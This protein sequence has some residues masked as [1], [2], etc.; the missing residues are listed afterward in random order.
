MGSTPLQK[1]V[2][3]GNICHERLACSSAQDWQNNRTEL[4]LLFSFK[5]SRSDGIGTLLPAVI[6]G[7]MIWR[8]VVQRGSAA[9]SYPFLVK[10]LEQ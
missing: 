4:L 3:S 10:Y 6:I 5:A 9:T 1:G 2:L 7:A 8:A